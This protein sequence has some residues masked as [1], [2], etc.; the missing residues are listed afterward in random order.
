MNMKSKK[1]AT[2]P[3][4]IR[5]TLTNVVSVVGETRKAVKTIDHKVDEVKSD[6]AELKAEVAEVKSDVAELKVDIVEIKNEQVETRKDIA[7]LEL[8]IRQLIPN[9]NN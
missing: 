6:I 1:P 4:H 5:D 7:R 3:D 9:A 8:L 2:E